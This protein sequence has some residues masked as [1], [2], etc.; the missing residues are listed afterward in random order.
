MESTMTRRAFAWIMAVFAAFA[1]AFAIA[2]GTAQAADDLAAGGMATQADD[3]VFTVYTQLGNGKAVVSKEYTQADLDKLAAENKAVNGYL[4][5]A[6]GNK[7]F[8]ADKY[9]TLKQLKASP[10]TGQT[11]RFVTAD[12]DLDEDSGLTLY[13]K[14]S[15]NYQNVNADLKFFPAFDG[16][17]YATSADDTVVD[18]VI[19]INYGNGTAVATTAAA[20]LAED[21]KDMSAHDGKFR[22]FMGAKES[23]Y[24]EKTIPA[25]KASP[26]GVT[27]V[28]LTTP[29]SDE[30]TVYEQKDAESEAKLVKEYKK[31]DL[32]KLA[33]KKDAG[34]LFWKGDAWNLVATSEYVE[35][36]KLLKDAGV[37]FDAGDQLVFEAA[38]GFG[39]KFPVTY[40]EYV[41]NKY[42]YPAAT[43]TGTSTDG[44]VEIGTLLALNS[45]AGKVKGTAAETLA[46]LAKGAENQYRLLR[47]LTEDEYTNKAAAGNRLITAPIKV[48]VVH[49]DAYTF[50]ESN[51]TGVSS[52]YYYTGKAIEPKP[53]VSDEGAVLMEGGAYELEYADNTKASLESTATVT[54][55]GIGDF[56]GSEVVKKFAILDF[57]DTAGHWA[58]DDG[59][60]NW[61]QEATD[62]G[63]MGG[64]KDDNGKLNG[65]FG[66]DDKIS[67]AQVAVMLYRSANPNSTDTTDP[68]NYATKNTT[69]WTDVETGKY[70]TAAMNWA[71]EA[72]VFKGDSDTNFTTVRPDANI[73]R[74]E[75]ATVYARYADGTGEKADGSYK[76]APDAGSVAEWA[77]AGIDW[78]YTNKV[79]TGNKETKALNPEDTA[80]RAET[81]KMTVTT[82]GIKAAAPAEEN[83]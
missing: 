29:E 25:G 66:P 49:G 35:I 44:A 47:S 22:F 70:Y 73:S 55:K 34:S 83:K 5:N 31:E 14:A 43:E 24:T 80:T 50:D 62:Q 23:D 37:K 40:G 39:A 63:L 19:A 6:K 20:A 67:R 68:A 78:C 74:Q 16:A 26:D 51:V 60:H 7:V 77:V 38:D 2:P 32:Q 65:Q 64:Y 1:V 45:T 79:M 10:A 21:Q 58:L 12:G 36:G 9:V 18:A 71:K 48:T 61:I 30:F 56:E 27:G 53:V 75:L 13:G 11:L 72:G 28:L 41:L 46:T 81:A 8:A 42:F 15:L 4:Y 82:V 57:T 69:G 33:E 3:V 54:I 52:S 76:N 59:G 17:N